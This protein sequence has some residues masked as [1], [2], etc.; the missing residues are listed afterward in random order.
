MLHVEGEVFTA[1]LD[2]NLEDPLN[3]NEAMASSDANLWHSA[4]NAEIELMYS[5]SVWTLVD[6]PEGVKPIGC[7]WIYKR[8]RGP[9]GNVETYKTR[10]V[11]KGYM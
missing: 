10:L 3:Y 4:M 8:K 11:A 5:N 1:V 2:D 6:P 9:D 7:K